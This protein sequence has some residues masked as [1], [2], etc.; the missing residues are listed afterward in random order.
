MIGDC[1]ETPV[2]P[3]SWARM[4]DD[5]SLGIATLRGVV[6]SIADLPEMMAPHHVAD[7]SRPYGR[8]VLLNGDNLE[9]MIATWTPGVR[10]APHD[11]GGSEGVVRV[12]QGRARHRIYAVRESGLEVVREETASVGEILVCGKHLV[13]SM[14]DDGAELPLVTLHMYTGPVPHMVVYDVENNRTLKV[15]GGCGAWVPEPE[16]GMLLSEQPGMVPIQ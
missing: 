8:H 11:H 1:I 12:L 3:P 4:S 10:C 5:P 15:A 14:G 9:V 13:H 2:L 16:S 7:P 6:S